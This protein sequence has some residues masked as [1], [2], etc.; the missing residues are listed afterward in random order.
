MR[1]DSWHAPR[2]RRADIC[3]L[4]SGEISGTFGL[5]ELCAMYPRPTKTTERMPQVQRVTYVMAM[6]PAALV[7]AVMA[8]SGP[9]APAADGGAVV[10]EPVAWNF[11]TTPDP[12]DS[13]LSITL[14]GGGCFA[15]QEQI[16]RIDVE[17]D[18]NQVTIG[19]HIR[20]PTPQPQATCPAIG[21]F[22]PTS[23]ELESDLGQ[24]R[25]ID[26]ATGEVKHR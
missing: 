4:R 12:Q 23:V 22:H 26:A 13:T 15:D 17:E 10:E 6:R 16:G 2:H 3:S 14:A 5:A 24:R 11:P 18:S 21:R 7:L 19:A 25:V 20:K 8:C 9:P 1:W